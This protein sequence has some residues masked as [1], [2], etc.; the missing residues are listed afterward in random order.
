MKIKRYIVIYPISVDSCLLNNEEVKPQVGDFY[1]GW[2]TS[3]I[4]GPFKGGVG[5]F[6]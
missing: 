2:I 5:S 6:G 1:G 4:I 3:D